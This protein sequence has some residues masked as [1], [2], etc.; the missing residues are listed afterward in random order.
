MATQQTTYF[1]CKCIHDPTGACFLCCQPSQTKEGGKSILV[2]ELGRDRSLFFLFLI[3]RVP[4]VLEM[5]LFC[6]EESPAKTIVHQ[7]GIWNTE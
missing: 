6:E 5:H 3:W 1:D 4:S 7:L 2:S